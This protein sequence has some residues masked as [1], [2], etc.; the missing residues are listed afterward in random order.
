MKAVPLPHRERRRVGGR[1]WREDR[2]E[3]IAAPGETS[4]RGSGSEGRPPGETSGFRF[5]EKMTDG[6]N[7]SLFFV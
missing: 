2:W 7:E 6:T 3:S 1:V 4:G 5:G